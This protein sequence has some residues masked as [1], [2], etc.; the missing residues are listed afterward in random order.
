MEP[1]TYSSYAIPPSGVLATGP[2][3]MPMTSQGFSSMQGGGSGIYAPQLSVPA[4]EPV[5]MEAV[6]TH[7]T[8]T[9]LDN[10]PS[11][12]GLQPVPYAGADPPTPPQALSQLDLNAT[13]YNPPASQQ[14]SYATSSFAMDSQPPGTIQTVPRSMA[15]SSD[16]PRTGTVPFSSI[17]AQGSPPFQSFQAPQSS[18][19]PVQSAKFQSGGI[20]TSGGLQ[21][22]QADK[23][24]DW[25]SARMLPPNTTVPES[26]KSTMSPRARDPTPPR[27][28]ESMQSVPTKSGNWQPEIRSVDF[29]KSGRS[30]EAPP[31]SI[32][33]MDPDQFADGSKA[34]TGKSLK[35]DDAGPLSPRTRSI[36]P[37]LKSAK[38]EKDINV[39]KTEDYKDFK[40]K[41]NEKENLISDIRERDATIARLLNE[42]REKR[43][44]RLREVELLTDKMDHLEARLLSGHIDPH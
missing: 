16:P 6:N 13:V 31:Q 38:L 18:S 12:S 1:A 11:V 39:S 24:Q 8:N 10:F 22:M 33:T 30:L 2:P 17:S 25:A 41:E 40:D 14:Y 5:Y 15:T 27:T 23:P 34:Y 35:A 7:E 42:V 43:A 9:T 26:R 19:L 37:S 4:Q 29:A 36:K 21:D 44:I 32:K 20:T 28:F 3:G